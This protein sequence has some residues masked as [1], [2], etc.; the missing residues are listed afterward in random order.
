MIV[1]NFNLCISFFNKT[2]LSIL[3]FDHIYLIHPL[4]FGGMFVHG[5]LVTVCVPF[6]CNA[7]ISLP[8]VACPCGL[9]TTSTY[10]LGSTSLKIVARKAKWE[11]DN[12][13]VCQN[14]WIE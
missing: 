5:N 4:T 10:E 2:S 9:V 3:S 8:T 12:F 7:L 13:E 6:C 1:N 14:F 11:L